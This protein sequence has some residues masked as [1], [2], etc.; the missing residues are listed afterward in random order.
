M[1]ARVRTNRTLSIFTNVENDNKNGNPSRTLEYLLSTISTIVWY[2]VQTS[3]VRAIAGSN[4]YSEIYYYNIVYYPS[5][6]ADRQ[7]LISDIIITNSRFTQHMQVL[8]K[9]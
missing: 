6:T 8:H 2:L 3:R 4:S 7:L 1:C 9:W 5:N